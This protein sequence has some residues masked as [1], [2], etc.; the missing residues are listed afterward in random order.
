MAQS[1]GELHVTRAHVERATEIG[2]AAQGLGTIVRVEDL[3]VRETRSGLD[4]H[5]GRAVAAHD[6]ARLE[7]ERALLERNHEIC[8]GAFE[9]AELAMT[10]TVIRDTLARPCAGGGCE[11]FGAGIGAGGY[12]GGHVSL[13]RFVIERSALAGLQIARDGAVDATG[14]VIRDNPIGAN[15]QIPGYDLT[16]VGRDVRYVD[17]GQNLDAT[18]LGV[19]EAGP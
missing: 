4:D 7:I 8:A 5:F 17:N 6:G 12:L 1:A 18:E 16:R 14:G 13:R 3:V 19:P 11:G 2:V 9:G 15:V 10:E